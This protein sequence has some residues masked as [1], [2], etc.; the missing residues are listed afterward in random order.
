MRYA[1]DANI[2]INFDTFLP[3]AYHKT[4]WKQLSEKVKEGGN[5]HT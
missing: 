5:Y 4:F 1:I 3:F 2:L